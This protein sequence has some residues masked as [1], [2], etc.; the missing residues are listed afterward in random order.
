MHNCCVPPAVYAIESHLIRI[1]WQDA[2]I[3]RT[4]FC[5][6]TETQN[7]NSILFKRKDNAKKTQYTYL[8]AIANKKGTILVFC[9]KLEP[10]NH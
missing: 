10:T 3:F 5:S 8:Q 1:R 9:L 2:A 6:S 7:L 4:I